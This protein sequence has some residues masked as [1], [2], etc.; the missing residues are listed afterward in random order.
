MGSRGASTRVEIEAIAEDSS[1]KSSE[2]SRPPGS[3]NPAEDLARLKEDVY[4]AAAYGDLEKLKRLVEEEHHL[5]TVPDSGGFYSLQW[6]AL[7]NKAVVAQYLLEHGADPNARDNSGQTALHWC[8]VRGAIQVAELL[9]QTG[10]SLEVADSHGYRTSHVAAQYGQTALLYHICTKWNSEVDA[11]DKDGRSPLHWAAY[12]GFVDPIRLLL[13]MDAYLGRQDKEGCTPLHWA[14]LRGNLEACTLLVQAGTKEDL[15][16]VDSTGC[17]PAQL[18]SDKGHRH[19]A[20]FLSNARKVYEAR[21]DAKGRFAKLTRMG[22][23]PLLWGII[24][25]LAFLFITAVVSSPS[26]PKITAG[27]AAWSWFAI[28]L[29]ITGLVIA[30]RATTADPGY[31]KANRERSESHKEEEPLMNGKNYLSNP[32]LW[33]GQWSQ[34]CPTC[35]IIR[36]VR[37]KHCAVCNRC[38][39]Q[40]DH[41]CPWI[42]NCVGK[43]NKYHFFIFLWIELAAMGITAAVTLHRLLM[44]EG[45]PTNLGP[46]LNHVAVEH[47]G[48]LVFLFGDGFMMASVLMLSVMQ[49]MQIARNITTN[50]MSNGHRYDY[51]KGEDGRFFNPYDRG[52]IQNCKDFFCNGQNEAI[53]VPWKPAVPPSPWVKRLFG[54]R[55][56]S[57]SHSGSEMLPVAL[58][59]GGIDGRESREHSHGPGCSHSQ[60]CGST[61]GGSPLGL[62]LG[63]TRSGHGL[64]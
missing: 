29:C 15:L 45:A 43:K 60:P 40:F 47:S 35:R 12:K 57:H 6:S 36:P 46:W 31:I 8:A 34:L 59:G 28:A 64:R 42:S 39:E 27:M 16:A 55:F 30:S 13:F 61:T 2:D 19:V 32:A 26:L 22:L 56:H 51:L 24:L 18:A 14:A 20:L 63:L 21:W 37:S 33:A 50:E 17:T 5:V 11:V 41:H 52:V 9:L 1:Q 3:S 25:G 7:N 54:G 23:A 49:A 48:A 53:V 58:T 4:T 10:A 44:D 38:V 62:G